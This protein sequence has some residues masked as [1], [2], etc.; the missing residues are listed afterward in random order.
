[1]WLRAE[2]CSSVPTRHR[3]RSSELNTIGL[4]RA[5]RLLEF[6][7]KF[8]FG[9]EF[10]LRRPQLAWT[11]RRSRPSTSGTPRRATR[12]PDD[13]GDASRSQRRQPQQLAS[14]LEPR[15]ESELLATSN[16]MS[17]DRQLESS[18][19]D[20]RLE[21][22]E[23]ADGDDDR[24]SGSLVGLSR[25]LGLCRCLYLCLCPCP[26]LLALRLAASLAASLAGLGVQQVGC[27]SRLPVALLTILI[28]GARDMEASGRRAANGA[29]S[30]AGL[31]RFVAVAAAAAVDVDVDVDVSMCLL[32]RFANGT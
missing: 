4:R 31:A 18:N 12:P 10:G 16:S 28:R 9:F 14:E 23:T 19:C 21:L 24:H 25:P 8:G 11:S 17:C 30:D 5:S 7:F 2:L 22:A 26:S 29:S 13:A 15:L 27:S 6:G 32:A 3:Q 20:H 1:M